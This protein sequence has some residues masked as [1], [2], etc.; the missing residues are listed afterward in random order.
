[1]KVLVLAPQPFYQE[2]G[3]PIAVRLA[4]EVLGRKYSGQNDRIDLL[5]YH[6]GIDI[7]IPHVQ[8]YRTTGCNKISQIPPG[9]SLK[10]ILVDL[11]FFFSALRLCWANRK[12]QYN[13]IHAVEE[14][15]FVAIFIQI[16][17]GIP[18]IYDMDS[19]IALQATEKWRLLKPLYPILIGAEK[20][21]VKL[22]QAVV[23]VCDTLAVLADKHG[24]KHTHILRD[25]SLVSDSEEQ[26]VNLK[27]ELG[28]G[29]SSQI[30]LYVGNLESYQ[31]VDL[32]VDSFLFIQN[33]LPDCHLV[34]IGGSQNHQDILSLRIR[35]NPSS[36]FV[37]IAG[38]R[39]VNL[40]GEYLKQADVLA[41]PRCKGNNTP[42]KIYSY[43]HAGRAIVATELP[44]HTQ[45]LNSEVAV[46]VE[47][48]IEAFAKGIKWLI[49]NPINRDKLGQAALDYAE[50]NF[51][52][53]VFEERLTTLY[54]KLERE[55]C[56]SSASVC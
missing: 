52:L 10:K 23:P 54:K 27:R 24:S 48:Q 17:F 25:V 6:E 37:H 49:K 22:S 14:S 34:I 19:S 32:L 45:V 5:V 8:I 30:V 1:M 2:R 29:D 3:T 55:V 20:L 47:P 16:F 41:S 35:E 9:I 18:Y 40:L 31:G 7:K 43:L 21:A 13:L 38:P 28:L 12:N 50:K 11:F 44:T 33:E 26:G 53:S 51:T 15:V 56:S 42:M 46:L 39:P 36:K 4:A